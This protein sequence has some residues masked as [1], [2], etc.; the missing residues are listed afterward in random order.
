MFQLEHG[1][2][3]KENT[4]EMLVEK[5]KCLDQNRDLLHQLKQGSLESSSKFYVESYCDYV[6]DEVIK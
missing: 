2:I 1:I 4:V 5:L 6:L 3:L